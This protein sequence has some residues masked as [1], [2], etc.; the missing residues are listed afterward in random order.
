[1]RRGA[2]SAFGWL[3]ARVHPPLEKDDVALV[4]LADLVR[5][6]RAKK[7]AIDDSG[8]SREVQT[9]AP[10]SLSLLPLLR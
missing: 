4:P 7:D 8:G 3:R 5:A 2:N 9:D 1:M 6:A 10:L